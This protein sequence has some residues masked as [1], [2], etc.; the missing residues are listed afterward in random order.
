MDRHEYLDRLI[1]RALGSPPLRAAVVFPV[2]QVSLLAALEAKSAGIITPVLVGP[3]REINEVALQSGLDIGGLPLLDAPDEASAA[4][5]AVETVHARGAD[6]LVKGSLHTSAFLRAVLLRGA[7][8]R[9]ARRA[10]HVFVFDVPAYDRPLLVTDAA[11]NVAPGLADKADICRNAVALAHALGIELPKVAVL[12]ALEVVDPSIPSTL[13]A[14]AL[15]KMAERGEISGA[16]VDGPLA[17]DDAISPAAVE[18]KHFASSVGGNADILVVPN[19]EAGNIL[20]KS[21]VYMG[22]ADVAGIVV[23]TKVPLVLT[24][25]ADTERS[26]VASAALAAVWSRSMPASD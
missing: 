17:L 15:S 16:V 8:M 2:D 20:Y 3:A 26:R 5:V 25:R 1:E 9:G 23:G 4:R 14:A 11:V 13:D 10:S 22:G 18:I 12:S 21:F 7:G 6:V 19:L 24:S